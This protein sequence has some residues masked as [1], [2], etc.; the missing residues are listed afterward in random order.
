MSDTE[1]VVVDAAVARRDRLAKVRAAMEASGLEVL[2]LSL[3]ADLPWLSGY[4]AMPLERPTAL[5][6]P[7][8]GEAT[9]FVPELEAPRVRDDASVFALRPWRESEDAI[10]LIA[11]AV[12]TRS[13]VGISDRAWAGLLLSLQEALPAASF[14]R[15]SSVTGP[16]RAVKDASEIAALKAAGAAADRVANA[17]LRGEIPLRGRSEAEVSAEIGARLL[18]E[19]HSRVNFAIVGSGPN[20]ASPHHEPGTRRIEHGDAVVCDFGGAFSLNG[21]VGYC[22]DTTRTVVV[23]EVPHRFA[24]LYAVLEDAQARAV[25]AVRS[26]VTAEEIDRVGRAV[27]E[28]AGFG[29][30]FMHRIG[31]GIGIEE[32]EDPYIVEG[33]ATLL[34]PGHA[35]SVEPG[36][37]LAGNTGARIED[38]VVVTDDGVL[39]CNESPHGLTF[40]DE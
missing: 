19:G 16:L 29:E 7:K 24:E 14:L 2:V 34:V 27:I 28:E 21:D 15:A 13:R 10:G 11:T 18:A 39:R 17:L 37:Y 12:G 20:A 6:V 25:D 40:V 32:H 4:E 1:E 22:S 9:L 38:I 8:D 33:N 5:V 3:G 30:E 31:H 26:G 36:I 35:F 23:G